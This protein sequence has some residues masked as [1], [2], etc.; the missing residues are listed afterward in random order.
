MVIAKVDS[1]ATE[2]ERTRA[3]ATDQTTVVETLLQRYHASYKSTSKT[4]QNRIDQI[5]TWIGVKEGDKSLSQRL[6]ELEYTMVEI[7]EQLK[8]PLAAGEFSPSVPYC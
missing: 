1:L 2:L 7:T 4:S 6:S 5:Q 8:D 3:H